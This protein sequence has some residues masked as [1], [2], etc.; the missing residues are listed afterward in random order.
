MQKHAAQL[1]AVDAAPVFVLEGVPSR[2]NHP[3]L[4]EA[5][6]HDPFQENNPLF[7]KSKKHKE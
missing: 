6:Q 5:L 4:G 3:Y 1:S 2:M 7:P